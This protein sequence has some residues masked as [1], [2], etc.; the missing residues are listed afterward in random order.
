[1]LKQQRPIIGEGKKVQITHGDNIFCVKKQDLYNKVEI[2]CRKKEEV[3]LSYI[4]GIIIAIRAITLKDGIIYC[5]FQKENLWAKR[6]EL[7]IQRQGD[8]YRLLKDMQH[9]D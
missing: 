7:K 4:L 9:F 5:Y 8:L 3:E 6:P 1:M 2:L